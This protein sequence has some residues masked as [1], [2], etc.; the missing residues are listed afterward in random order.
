MYTQKK[1]RNG[2]K[3]FSLVE[4]LVAITILLIA[5]LAPMR[6]VSQS[7]K[8]AALAGEQLTATFLAQEGIESVARLRDGDVLDEDAVTWGWYSS[9]LPACKDAT[10]CS[11][12]VVNNSFIA[13]SGTSCA[14]KFDE[15]ATNGAY[16]YHGSG[17]TQ[18]RY[19]RVMSVIQ[20]TTGEVEV[21]STVSWFSDTVQDTVSVQ[22]RTRIFDQYG[23]N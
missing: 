14:L 23:G 8:A 3:G 2:A 19:T 13:C 12:D 9:L 4:T 1:K 15:N 22:L 18:S 10:G 17:G 11:Y 6:I 21:T 7:I 20:T 16:Y 5:V